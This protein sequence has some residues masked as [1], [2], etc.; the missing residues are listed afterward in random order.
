MPLYALISQDS[1][2]TYVP[3]FKRIHHTGTQT[4]ISQ[5]EDGWRVNIDL[6]Q[7]NQDPVTIVGYLVPT[8]ALAKALADK[9]VARY[10]HTCDESCKD[11]VEVP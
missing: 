11:W 10:G 1:Q 7:P 3:A 5:V 6:R 4:T 8:I 9:E 2:R